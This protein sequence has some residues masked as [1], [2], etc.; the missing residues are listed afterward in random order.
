MD[1]ATNKEDKK[2]FQ[3]V[4]HYHYAEI[5]YVDAIDQDDAIEQIE[6]EGLECDEIYKD[7]DFYD[8]MEVKI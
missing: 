8:Y 2:R 4:K 5:Y 7:F 3:V 6:I 1:T